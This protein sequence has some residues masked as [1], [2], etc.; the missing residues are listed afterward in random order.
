MQGKD[1]TYRLQNKGHLVMKTFG[2]SMYPLLHDS[3]VV[4]LKKTAFSR[5]K[6]NDII[7]FKKYGTLQTHRIIYKTDTYVITKGDN[8]LKADGKVHERQIIGRVFQV[9]R[10]S[11]IFD[12]EELYLVQSSLY[13]KEIVKIKKAFEKAGIDF[14][15]L[16][17][18]PL[19][20]YYEGMHPR[21][22]YADCDVLIRKEHYRRVT[23]TLYHNGYEKVYPQRSD[24]QEI[25]GYQ[26]AQICFYR[27]F[28]NL[29]ILF[30]IHLEPVFA[31]T[32]LGNFHLLYPKQTNQELSRK[33]IQEKHCA[34][35]NDI[36]FPLLSFTNQLVYL[37]LHFHKHDYKEIRHLLL[38]DLVLSQI[39]S[40]DWPTVMEQIIET[41]EAFHLQNFIYPSFYLLQEYGGEKAKRNIAPLLRHLH[42]KKRV[43]FFSERKEASVFHDIHGPGEHFRALLYLS[44]APHYKKVLVFFDKRLLSYAASHIF[45]QRPLYAAK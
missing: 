42:V 24:G 26:D 1:L 29:P 19:H 31:T 9:K 44:P 25:R 23:S 15:F 33:F 3:D 37:A 6:V 12:P 40:S 18:L 21:R 32:S 35:I 36:P 5:L 10:G 41:A 38:M 16:K 11:E 43:L 8:N 17:G 13:F 4:Y 34:I 20:L 45:K 14:V 22:M 28:A 7:C 27:S 2:D 39:S 30:E